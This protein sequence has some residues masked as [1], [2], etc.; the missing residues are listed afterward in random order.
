[1]VLRLSPNKESRTL[2]LCGGDVTITVAHADMVIRT[3]ALNKAKSQIRSLKEGGG[4]LEDYN[5]KSEHIDA[6]QDGNVLAGFSQL[7]FAVELGEF[8]IESWTGI[9]LSDGTPAPVNRDVIIEL[10]S[11]IGDDFIEAEARSADK[12]VLEGNVFSPSR[13]GTGEGAGTTAKAA[14]PKTPPARPAGAA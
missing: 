13:N 10:M 5:Y 2:S 7:I 8:I 9:E 11:Q 3:A 12:L 14:K 4:V 1:M 6:L